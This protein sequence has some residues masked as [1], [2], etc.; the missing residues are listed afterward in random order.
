MGFTLPS[1][2]GT[3]IEMARVKWPLGD[4]EPIV[5]ML[6]CLCC[7]LVLG[8]YLCKALVAVCSYLLSALNVLV[9]S[10]RVTLIRAALGRDIRLEGRISGRM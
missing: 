8:G 3:A 1:V 7:A 9:E 5:C 6:A 4:Y 10:W 2:G